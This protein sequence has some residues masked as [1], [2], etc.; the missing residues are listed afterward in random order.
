[1]GAEALKFY[2]R[3]EIK[4]VLL[5]AA[6]DREASVMFGRDSFGK[7]PDVLQFEGDVLELAKKGATSFHIS[8]ELWRDPLELKP[9]MSKKDLDNLRI[10]W[11]CILDIDT[12]F[13]EYS[14]ITAELIIEAL[15]F[16]DMENY[17][18]KYSGSNGFHIGIP[19]KSF[20]EKVNG[21][22]TRLLFPEGVRVIANYIKELI[23]K[24]LSERILNIDSIQE[25]SETLNK[26]PSELIQKGMFNPYTVLDI[27]TVLISSR[28]LFRAPY[29]LNEKKGLVS[30][31]IKSIK[32]FRISQAKPSN[33]EVNLGFLDE[34][35]IEKSEASQLII[36]AF[37]WQSKNTKAEVIKVKRE[38]SLPTTAIKEEHF[39][40]C[41]KLLSKGIKE[42]GRKRSVFILI[43]FLKH[44][45]W[46]VDQIQDYL[47]KWN[48]KNVEELR[49]G[50]IKAQINWHKKQKENILPPNCNSE[51]YYKGMDVCYP[52]NL[53]KKIKN[54]IN[55]A[56]RKFKI[57]NENKKPKKK[58]K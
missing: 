11:S 21:V 6:K 42:D 58:K 52:D 53:C 5:E 19:F 35:K 29:S 33:V 14:K 12:K 31:P 30:I 57:L 44:M 24:H 23:K 37:D 25:I 15:K 56:H 16:H 3:R 51:M 7:R 4:K 55:Y 43:N 46:E 49:E 50:Y 27:D 40:P 22:E 48:K 54:P 10:G 38:F 9:G 26:A 47:L 28:H 34:S 36:Q 13:L 1:M 17:S 20:P 32:N 2:S 41:I 45:G 18:L 8:E 39:P